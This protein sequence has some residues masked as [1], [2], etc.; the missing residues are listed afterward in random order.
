MCLL[1]DTATV[2]R[3]TP[4]LTHLSFACQ[5]PQQ[6]ITE[7]KLKLFSSGKVSMD[8]NIEQT[9]FHQGNFRPTGSDIFK[10]SIHITEHLNSAAA[11]EKIFALEACRAQSPYAQRKVCC[12]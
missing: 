7:K 9:G 5:S 11:K 6:D 10:S 2:M 1:C 8:T 12:P 3:I 4:T